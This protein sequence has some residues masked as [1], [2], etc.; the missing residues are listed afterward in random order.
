MER[1]YLKAFDVVWKNSLGNI[2]ASN[3]G[4]NLSDGLNSLSP[5]MY[6]IESSDL[7]CGSSVDSVTVNEPNQIVSQFTSSSDTIYMSNGASI[8]FINQS[9]NASY[10]EWDFGD[11]NT[12][13]SSSPN[14]QYHQ[15]GTYIVS[16][17]A[18]QQVGCNELTSTIITVL[19]TYTGIDQVSDANNIQVV[20]QNTS[21]I[22]YAVNPK[23]IEV[24]N[25]IGQVVLTSS[26][27]ENHQELELSGLSSQV[28][29]VKVSFS[30]KA[31][32]KK[33]NFVN[34]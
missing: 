1:Y 11:A 28:L 14:N 16:L 30:N 24:F 12:S 17:N 8:A 5:G 26:S 29:I 32:Y 3:I 20:A 25:A 31:Y 9:S 13:N 15:A 34:F 18:F 23:R 4:V 27:P 6:T 21:L 2:I 33:V 10:Y 19:N 7:V 22:V